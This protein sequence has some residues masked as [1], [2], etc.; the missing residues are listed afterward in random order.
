VADRVPDSGQ[1][2]V[3]RP[4]VKIGVPFALTNHHGSRVTTETFAGRFMLIYFGFTHCKVVCPRS[5]RRLSSVLE[6]LGPLASRIQ[7]L[8]VTVDPE[9]DTPAVMKAFLESNYPLFLGLTG[10]RPEIDTM[11][12]GYR[13]F[14]EAVEDAQEQDGYRVPH[15]AFSYLVSPQGEYVTHFSDAVEAADIVSRLKVLVV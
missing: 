7:P 2:I 1:E 4:S 5:L 15:T 6:E 13:V 3:V 8:Y 10:S 14:A 9:R 12:A 11:K